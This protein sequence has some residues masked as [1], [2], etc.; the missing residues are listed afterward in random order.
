[1]KALI[2]RVKKVS[3]K[4]EGEKFSEIG[5]GLLIFLGVKEGDSEKDCQVFG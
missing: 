1:M 2:Q 4:I 5:S 3:V